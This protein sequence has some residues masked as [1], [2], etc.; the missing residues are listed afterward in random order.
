[1]SSESSADEQPVWA[2]YLDRLGAVL[3]ITLTYHRLLPDGRSVKFD[4]DPA[5]PLDL[6][7]DQDDRLMEEGFVALIPP[8]KLMSCAMR[9]RAR[10]LLFWDRQEIQ[11]TAAGYELAVVRELFAGRLYNADGAS[12]D[13][14]FVG[15]GPADHT[16]PAI[17]AAASALAQLLGQQSRASEADWL[18]VLGSYQAVLYT[19]STEVQMVTR[20]DRAI[21][22]TSLSALASVSRRYGFEL[23]PSVQ[24]FTGVEG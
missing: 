2:V 1:M 3:T 17:V 20:A 13:A 10:K 19:E 16:T 15:G 24:R 21:V 14:L 9:T 12:P 4:E 23:P 11:H 7:A 8:G 18:R 22:A 5:G 6:A